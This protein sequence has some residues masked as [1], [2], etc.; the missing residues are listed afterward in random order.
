MN[1]I[2]GNRNWQLLS[3]YRYSYVTPRNNN[4]HGLHGITYI[5]S[6]GQLTNWI[7]ASESRVQ[8]NVLQNNEIF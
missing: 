2:L 1:S 5:D 8:S 3:H 4:I 6:R 7:I